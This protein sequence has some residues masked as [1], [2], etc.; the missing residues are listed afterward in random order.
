MFGENIFLWWNNG[1]FMVG[2][3]VCFLVK[4]IVFYLVHNFSRYK[5]K[6]SHVSAFLN[7]LFSIIYFDCYFSI[8]EANC[9]QEN[10]YKL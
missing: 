1:F 8:N 4:A 2:I 5:E 3:A 6:F 7:I 10:L 9:H